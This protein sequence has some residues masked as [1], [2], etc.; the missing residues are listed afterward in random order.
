MMSNSSGSANHPAKTTVKPPLPPG[1]SCHLSKSMP[2]HC[3]Y[4]NR[5][6]G[7]RTWDLGEVLPG[8]SEQPLKSAAAGTAQ[9]TLSRD[10]QQMVPRQQSRQQMTGYQHPPAQDWRVNQYP[11]QGGHDSKPLNRS[12]GNIKEHAQ[13][14]ASQC[15]LPLDHGRNAP[16]LQQNQQR[17]PRLTGPPL[18]PVPQIEIG[19]S[20]VDDGLAS[21]GVEDLQAML[22]E[23]KRKLDQMMERQ[24]STNSIDGSV[25]SSSV[26]SGFVS[27]AGREED[28]RQEERQIGDRQRE[29]TE[30]GGLYSNW[31]M[32]GIS[33]QKRMKINDNNADEEVTVIAVS[34]AKNLDHVGDVI[35]NN[36][37]DKSVSQ[38]DKSEKNQDFS[39]SDGSISEDLYAA[40]SEEIALLNNLEK[41][42]PEGKVKTPGAVGAND[43][44]T[45]QKSPS[46]SELTPSY[47]DCQFSPEPESNDED[48]EG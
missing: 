31:G 44:G 10:Q 40:D 6:T 11:G 42:F 4:F 18:P 13:V 47:D 24:S 38:D 39:D 8:H 43:T 32:V 48:S 14:S 36:S 29:L 34:R 26:E 33:S 15:V 12:G 3:Y 25:E 5:F 9:S 20:N 37:N 28:G 16:Y 22:A 46:I 19:S 30:R 35:N 23:K 21:M 41:K 27:L 7:A 17:R 1:W 2:G 45:H